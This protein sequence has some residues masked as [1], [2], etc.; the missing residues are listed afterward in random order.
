MY[1][2]ALNQHTPAIF[3]NTIPPNGPH[4]AM[5][6]QQGGESGIKISDNIMNMNTTE[7]VKVPDIPMR[8][9]GDYKNDAHYTGG[10]LVDMENYIAQIGG[11]VRKD[12]SISEAFFDLKLI[13]HRSIPNFR[14]TTFLILS[15]L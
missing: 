3:S 5:N 9:G 1:V 8:G 7:A 15:S 12:Q 4:V 6:C 2:N 13:A 11:G 10:E 14:N